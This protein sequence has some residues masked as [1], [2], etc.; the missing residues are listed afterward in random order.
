MT[1]LVS[2]SDRGSLDH[3]ECYCCSCDRVYCCPNSCSRA[4]TEQPIDAIDFV[5]RQA[6][7][8]AWH[9]VWD[10]LSFQYQSAVSQTFRD[11]C[12]AACRI[13]DSVDKDLLDRDPDGPAWRAIRKAVG[14]RDP[15]SLTGKEAF[16]LAHQSGTYAAHF[17]SIV[18][19]SQQVEG[20]K[21]VVSARR[22]IKGRSQECNLLMVY[23]FGV[24]RIDRIQT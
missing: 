1:V 9:D 24:W 21:A 23:E 7:A 13:V 3:A 19:L 6:K 18:A 11:E 10:R 4:P 16:I 17:Q 22:S 20:D 2:S 5:A 8:G 12:A 15:A 14:E